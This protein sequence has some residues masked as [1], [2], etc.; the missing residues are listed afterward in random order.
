[1]KAA[2]PAPLGGQTIDAWTVHCPDCGAPVEVSPGEEA[3]ACKRCNGAFSP[4]GAPTAAWS[5]PDASA[6]SD[7]DDPLVGQRLGGWLLLR[8]VGRGGMGRVYEATDAGGR[9]RVA[10]KVLSADLAADAAF[11]SRFRREARVLAALSHPHVVEIHEQGEDDGRLY[12]VMEYVRGENLRRRMAHGRL[13]VADAVRIAREV[14]SALSYAHG[15]G[16]VHRD[17][18]PENV[19]LDEQGVV[20]LADFGLSRLLG[21]A[22]PEATTFLTRTDVILGTYEYMAPE[23]RRGDKDLDGRADVFALGVILYEMLTGTLPLGSF[24]PPS[25]I[26][27]D[28]PPALDAVVNRALAPDPDARYAGADELRVAL[29]E[30]AAARIPSRRGAPPAPLA[31]PD[32]RALRGV[33]KHVDVLSAVDR[34]L[35]LLLVLGAFGLVPVAWLAP[36]GAWFLPIGGIAFL[37]AFVAGVLFLKQGKQLSL[38]APDARQGQVT[39]SILL[40][41]FP[42]V[43]TAVGVY[44]LVVCTSDRARRAFTVGRKALE[45]PTPVVLQRVVEVARPARRKQPW[46]LLKLLLG[47]ALLW[48]LYVAFVAADVYRQPV[49]ETVIEQVRGL[50]NEA[51]DALAVSVA[52]LLLSGVGLVLAFQARKT[53]RGVGVALV[54]FLLFAADA[55]ALSGLHTVN[56][57]ARARERVTRTGSWSAPPR[58]ALP[59]PPSLP[60]LEIKR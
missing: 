46:L 5:R 17:L 48:T 44:G 52:G 3:V 23:Q 2:G 47:F 59:L 28:V 19:L 9:R 35:G 57:I 56:R 8:L 13:P 30:A 50:P 6:P 40:L 7:P 53:R 42:P 38:L 29:E 51:L 21:G 20:H 60:R 31:D 43:L 22:A 34:V 14:A 1:M 41:F 16:V 39:A 15:R 33:L 25:E 10:L 37:V 45:G 12:F 49:A 11:V 26:A 4:A 58:H 36:V 27:A 54:S 18:K 32:V 24:R 55:T